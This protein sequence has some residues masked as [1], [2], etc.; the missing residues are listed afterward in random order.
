HMYDF[1]MAPSCLHFEATLTLAQQPHDESPVWSKGESSTLHID[2]FAV[3]EIKLHLLKP[4][5]PKWLSF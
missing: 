2:Q 1:A 3:C 4:T 5:R